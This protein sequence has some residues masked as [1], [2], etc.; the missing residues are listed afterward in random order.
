MADNLFLFSLI[1]IK[2]FTL[3]SLIVYFVFSHFDGKNIKD[4]R[5]ELIQLKTF[6]LMLRLS[7]TALTIL[8]CLIFFMPTLSASVP[9]FVFMITIVYGEIFGK[10]YYRKT[11]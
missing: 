9:I 5:E 4:E 2:C 11:L 6:A 7:L 1:F 8:S 10:A 3:V